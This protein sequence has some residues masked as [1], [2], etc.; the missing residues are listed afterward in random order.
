MHPFRSIARAVRGRRVGSGAPAQARLRDL[1]RDGW[2]EVARRTVH[3]VQDDNV[4]LLSAGVAF[5]WFISLFPAIAAALGIYGLSADPEQVAR[6]SETIA[7]LLPDSSQQLLTD[8]LTRLTAA[9]DRSLGLGVV[10]A[11]L[12]ALWTTSAGV[13]G[14]IRALNLAYDS[15]EARNF[16]RRRL[17]SLSITVGAVAFLTTAVGLLALTPI[18]LERIALGEAAEVLL[19]FARW[20]MLLLVFG[21]AVTVLY[22]LAPVQRPEHWRMFSAGAVLAT[23]I[24]LLGSVGFSVYVQTIAHYGNTYGGIAGVIALLMWLFTTAFAI[25]LG[26]EFDAEARRV[27]EERAAARSA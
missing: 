11:V 25:L 4:Q 27:A 18:L 17:L 26:A 21:T 14:V 12:G 5:W 8:H 10:V 3:E 16:L 1:D 7:A 13:A 19:T 24:W 15:S 2:R 9:S 23:L 6:Q 20:P 22:R